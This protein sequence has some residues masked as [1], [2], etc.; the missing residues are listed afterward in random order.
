MNPTRSEDAGDAI[1]CS[2]YI[3]LCMAIY[4]LRTFFQRILI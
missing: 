4:L 3:G 1:T 2:I